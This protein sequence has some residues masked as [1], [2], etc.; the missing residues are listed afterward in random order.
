MSM[1]YHASGD[2][3]LKIRFTHSYGRVENRDYDYELMVGD[4]VMFNSN[5]EHTIFNSKGENVLLLAQYQF[6][7][8]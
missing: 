8:P 1:I 3:N 7:N 2:D 6:Q 4:L 5:I